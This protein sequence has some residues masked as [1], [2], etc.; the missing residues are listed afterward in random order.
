MSDQA[1]VVANRPVEPVPVD[2]LPRRVPLPAIVQTLWSVFGMDSFVQFC[3]KRYPDEKLLAFRIIGIGDVI[4]VLDPQLIREVFSGDSEA[5]RGGEANAQALGMLGPNSLLLLD[6]E[7]HLH[8]RR[9][10]LPPFHGEAIAHHTQLIEQITAAEVDHWPIGKEFALWPRMRAITMEV[11]LRTVI[12]V[13]DEQRRRLLG[14]LLPAFTHGG[15]FAALAQVR[16]PWLAGGVIGERLPWVKARVQ[17]ERLLCEE[18]ADHRASPEDR[19]DVLTMLVQARDEHGRELSDEELL[20][21]I[22]TL[23][24]AGHDTTAAALA[25]CFERVLRHPDVLA[26]CRDASTENGEYLTAVVNET[27]RVR[28]VV[29]SA[30][31]K[32][33]A[34]FR[35]GGY[36]LPA[37]TLVTASIRGVQVRPEFYSEPQRFQPERFLERPTPYTFIPFGGGER[38]CIGAS[39][40]MMEIKTVLQ[41]VMQRI[42]LHA[43]NPRD[44]RSNRT[45]SIAIVPARGTRVIATARRNWPLSPASTGL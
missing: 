10:L 26:R 12:G 22:L 31:R 45:R 14:E 2:G 19:N 15:V 20:D 41:T 5:L 3:I 44:E 37:G 17:A 4:S 38:R 25:W 33:S 13:Q 16:L 28:P 8:A 34:P 32:L 29:D 7:P 30:P 9:L 35:L 21:H 1:T 6:G 23:L 36:R 39:F 42:E 24:G 43:A 27:L 18:I 11:I 40:A